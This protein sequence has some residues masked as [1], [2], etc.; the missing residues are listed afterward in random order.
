MID[1]DLCSYGDQDDS[2]E[3]FHIDSFYFSEAVTEANPGEG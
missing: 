2:P 1:K 3:Q